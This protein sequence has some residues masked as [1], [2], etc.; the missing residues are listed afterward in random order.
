MVR[1]SVTFAVGMHRRRYCFGGACV[2]EAV[3]A[4]DDYQGIVSFH[5]VLQS[6]PRANSAKPWLSEVTRPLEVRGIVSSV[7][8]FFVSS[9]LSSVVPPVVP[10]VATWHREVRSRSCHPFCRPLCHPLC[11]PL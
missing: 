2:L 5:G 4:G 11:H 8:S 6:D 7:V 1:G 10:S 3:R 9:V